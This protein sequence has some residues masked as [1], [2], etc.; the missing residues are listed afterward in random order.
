M[1]RTEGA[2]VAVKAAGALGDGHHHQGFLA[3]GG[4]PLTEVT[5]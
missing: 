4:K 5:V 2:H 1:A 3:V